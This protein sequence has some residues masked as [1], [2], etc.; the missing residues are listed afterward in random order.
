MRKV[1]FEGRES[2]EELRPSRVVL[3]RGHARSRSF[4][5]KPKSR[6]QFGDFNQVGK[7]RKRKG[8]WEVAMQKQNAG[9]G[10][11]HVG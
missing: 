11:W 1:K 6:G 3:E 5:L 9:C 7:R 4:D 8:R 2:E 10:K